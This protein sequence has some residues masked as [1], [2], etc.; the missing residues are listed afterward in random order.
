MITATSIS[1]ALKS[2]R[3]SCWWI[4]SANFL[5]TTSQLT[6]DPVLRQAHFLFWQIFVQHRSGESSWH[7][8]NW[9]FPVKYRNDAF[10][11]KLVVFVHN[12]SFISIKMN[13]LTVALRVL[14]F[15]LSCW[16]CTRTV[17]LHNKAMRNDVTRIVFILVV[18]L[19]FKF[20]CVYDMKTW[21]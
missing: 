19:P 5:L 16:E 17:K 8:G 6:G 18:Q 20:W 14:H 12:R 21:S 9:K 7:Y 3:I 11:E 4:S 13:P 15:P 2:V 1:S 10:M